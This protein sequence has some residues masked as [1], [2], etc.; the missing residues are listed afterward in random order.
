VKI[1]RYG[2]AALYVD[3]EIDDAPDR[4]PRT[5]AAARYL[6]G[7]LPAADV[8]IGAGAIVLAGTI[9]GDDVETLVAEAMRA[10][11]ID[12]AARRVHLVRTVYDGPDLEDA[13]RA[14]GLLPGELA[15]KHAAREYGVELLGFLPGFAYL[16]ELDPALV[17]PRRGAPRPRVPPGS[18]AIAGRYTGIYP[19]LSPGGWHLIGRAVDA[20][21][22]D[23]G[24]EPPSLFETG[25]R[26]KFVSVDAA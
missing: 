20:V 2:D 17:L 14:L 18:V 16:A 22:F 25:D 6:R 1:H 11:L 26:V 24:R 9:P 12:A 3:L 10:P 5:Q 7:R 23:S 21:L 19:L 4:A 15:K 8:V 13:A